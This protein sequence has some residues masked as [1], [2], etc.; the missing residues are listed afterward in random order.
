MKKQKIECA[1]IISKFKYHDELKSNLLSLIEKADSRVAE[2]AEAEV[3]ISRTD[4]HLS[5]KFSREWVEYV[6]APLLEHTLMVYKE[7]GY[8]GF[9]IHE[10]W[11]QQY[12]KN[13]EHGW[14]THS[15]NFTNVYYLELPIDSPKIKIVSPFNQTEIFELEVT[16]GDHVVF[17]SFAVHKS[18][19]NKSNFRKSIISYNAN[20]TYSNNIYGQGLTG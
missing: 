5:S 17:P 20:A 1:Y 9:T 4:W 3:Y 15:S 8:D 10:M 6:K 13:S 18:A 16:E 14:H 7:L 12:Y 2:D 19:A 11:F